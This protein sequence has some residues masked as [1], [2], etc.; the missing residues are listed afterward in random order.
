MAR[1]NGTHINHTQSVPS[2]GNRPS[3]MTVTAN[4]TNMATSV[5]DQHAILNA[6]GG[7]S[8][9]GS[10]DG[11]THVIFYRGATAYIWPLLRGM[12]LPPETLRLR[13]QDSTSADVK[14]SSERQANKIEAS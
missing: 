1:K 10:G 11:Y 14:L 7:W 12:F 3:L 13:R 4:T 9:F 5:R 8:L 6:V 2:A